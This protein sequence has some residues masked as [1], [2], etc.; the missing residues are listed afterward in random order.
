MINAIPNPKKSLTIDFSMGNTKKGVERISIV[1]DKYK[2]VNRN[3]IV[4][5]FTF[6]ALEFL[7]LG[8]L[9]DINLSSITE[10]KTTID[11]EI[12]RK[13]GTFNQSHEV[14][15]ANNHIAKIIELFS[16]GI[17]MSDD[18]INL[19]IKNKKEKENE[20]LIEVNGKM[21]SKNY[22]TNRIIALLVALGLIIFFVY[23]FVNRVR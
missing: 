14:T 22:K 5:Q 23:A 18:E 11:I 16:I 1:H 9:I 15:S 2:L 3:D 19:I 10:D 4:N 6:D 20:G 7:S 13:V 8:V 12:R 21:V 17:A